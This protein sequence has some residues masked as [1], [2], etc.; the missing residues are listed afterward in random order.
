M[1]CVKHREASLSL[2]KYRERERAREN[3]GE[4]AREREGGEG[5][6][7]GSKAKEV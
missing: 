4:R 1:L 3:A 7:V 5:G 2:C 6:A